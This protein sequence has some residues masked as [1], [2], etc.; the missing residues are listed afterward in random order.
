MKPIYLLEKSARYFTQ[1]P[2]EICPPLSGEIFRSGAIWMYAR[3][4]ELDNTSRPAFDDSIRFGLYGIIKYT[5]SLLCFVLSLVW[6]LNY[7]PLL[8]PLAIVCFYFAEVHFL[9]LF[10]LLIEKVPHPCLRSIQLTYQIG[11]T[12]TIFTVMV[13]GI[14]MVIGLFNISKPLRNWYIGCLAILLWYCEIKHRI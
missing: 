4:C 11:I 1:H 2:G 10:P 8:A 3:I 14:F 12:K 5:V 6:M 9:F 7:C 13:I